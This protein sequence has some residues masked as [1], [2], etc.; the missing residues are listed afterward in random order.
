M[1]DLIHGDDGMARDPVNADFHIMAI[2]QSDNCLTDP[3]DHWARGMVLPAL[4][5]GTLRS[6]EK[7]HFRYGGV[8]A[9]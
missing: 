1:G 7:V 4:A 9:R 2:M 3:H 6:C 8:S 5:D